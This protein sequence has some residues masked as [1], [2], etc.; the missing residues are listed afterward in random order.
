MRVLHDIV[1]VLPHGGTRCL[2]VLGFEWN[3]CRGS[4][5]LRDLYGTCDPC[6]P[7]RSLPIVAEV[8]PGIHEWP[9]NRFDRWFIAIVRDLRIVVGRCE[10]EQRCLL[11]GIEWYPL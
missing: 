1:H 7:L 5:S 4:S 2:A 3:M 10:H 9:T 11:S 8:I 6:A